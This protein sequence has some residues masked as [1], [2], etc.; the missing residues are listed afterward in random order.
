MIFDSQLTWKLQIEKV[1]ADMSCKIKELKMMRYLPKKV[2]STVYFKA[3]LPAV[4]Y[5]I[6]VGVVTAL[7]K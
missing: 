1:K 2:L 3:I 4:I 7:V 6:S 5:G